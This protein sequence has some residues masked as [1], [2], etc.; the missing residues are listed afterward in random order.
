MTTSGLENG[1]ARLWDNGGTRPPYE[2]EFRFDAARKWKFDFAWPDAKVAVEMQGGTWTQGGHTRGRG[3]AN[4]C[5]K[6]NRGQELGWIV[7]RFSIVH[8]EREPV[9][10]VER[11]E[12]MVRRR[13]GIEP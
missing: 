3:Y 13:L 8:M 9:Q 2:R 10:C 11:V 4:D 6:S 5:D 12:D 1:F 7:Y